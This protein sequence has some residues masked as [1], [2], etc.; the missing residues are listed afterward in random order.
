MLR[1][2]RGASAPNPLFLPLLGVH[3]PPPCAHANAAGSFTTGPPINL[4]FPLSFVKYNAVGE[5][6]TRS[7]KGVSSGGSE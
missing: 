1:M 7:G 2:K 6:C 3:S 5:N 4:A